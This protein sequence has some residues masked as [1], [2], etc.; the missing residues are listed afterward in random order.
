MVSLLIVV[1]KYFFHEQFWLINTNDFFGES[2]MHDVV[3]PGVW[4]SSMIST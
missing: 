4:S 3:L 1:T 2:M